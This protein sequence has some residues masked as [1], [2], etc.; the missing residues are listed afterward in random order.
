MSVWDYSHLESSRS[1]P[2]SRVTQAR[3]NLVESEKRWADR[4]VRCCE[5]VGI[6]LRVRKPRRDG[7]DGDE[8]DPQPITDHNF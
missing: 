6:L 5:Y 2:H 1:L 7:E 8:L 3:E 4:W